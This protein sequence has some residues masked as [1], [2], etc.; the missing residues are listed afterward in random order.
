MTDHP[1]LDYLSSYGKEPYAQ[2]P[3]INPY[4]DLQTALTSDRADPL[5]WNTPQNSQ[6]LAALSQNMRFP[7]NYMKLSQANGGGIAPLPQPP[8]APPQ[9]QTA[10]T[11]MMAQAQ[12][13]GGSINPP[14]PPARPADLGQ[15]PQLTPQQQLMIAA[16]PASGGTQGGQGNGFQNFF[17]RLLSDKAPIGHLIHSGLGV[18]QG[19]APVITQA[20][21]GLTGLLDSIFH[22]Q[23][24]P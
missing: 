2:A 21:G 18:A 23:G 5:P 16:A 1:L 17:D 7:D 11:Q 9:A 6:G 3:A 20:S 8:S 24:T 14:L 15:T 19:I 4:G 12:Q 10:N 13:P 22:A